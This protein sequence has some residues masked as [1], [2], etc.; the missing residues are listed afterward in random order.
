[1]IFSK[2]P[3]QTFGDDFFKA[4]FSNLWQQFSQSNLLKPLA[5]IFSKQPSQIFGKAKQ[6]KVPQITNDYSLIVNKLKKTFSNL[7]SFVSL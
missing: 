7:I 1:M 3:S 5:M 4:T 2:Q 6:N